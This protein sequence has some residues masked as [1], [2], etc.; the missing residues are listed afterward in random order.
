MILSVIEYCD[1]IYAGTSQG[2]LTK[3]DHLFYRV[4]RLCNSNNEYYNQK[5]LYIYIAN[6]QL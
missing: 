2:N 1:I 5:E 4:L 6:C 3:I